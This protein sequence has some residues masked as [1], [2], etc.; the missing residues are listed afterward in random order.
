MAQ[1][2]HLLQAVGGGHPHPVVPAELVSGALNVHVGGL[3]LLGVHHVQVPQLLHRS[4]AAPDLVGVKDHDDPTVSPA[5]VVA[6]QVNE[7]GPCPVQILSGQGGQVLP[8]V[9]DVVSIH[10]QVVLPRPLFQPLPGPLLGLGGGLYR[11]EGPGLHRPIGAGE[12]LLQLLVQGQLGGVAPLELGGGLGLLGP[13]LLWQPAAVHMHVGTHLVPGHVHPRPVVTEHRARGVVHIP[14]WVVAPL[15]HHL[16]GVVARAVSVQAAG[17]PPPAL[18]IGGHLAPV[19]PHLGHGQGPGEHRHLPP[20]LGALKL[21]AHALHVGHGPAHTL[22]RHLQAEGIPGL[23]Q[24]GLPHHQTLADG[25]VGGLAEVASLG[26]LQVALAGEQ[27][28]LQIGDGGPGEHPHVLAL[29]QVCENEPLPVAVQHVLGAHGVNLQSRPPLQRLQ[30]QVH[31][32]VV[33]QRLKVAHTFHRLG[34]SLQVDDAA[35]AEGDIQHEAAA[36][37]PLQHLPVHLAH[38]L[39][40]HLLCMWLPLHLQ[41]GVLL[42]QAAQ[43]LQQGGGVHPL[44]GN[45]LI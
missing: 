17:E 18:G 26:V 20:H 24:D 27:G 36:Q 43:P 2:D 33:A 30:K 7:L 5:L 1:N 39:H 41:L 34:Q 13:L 32:G 25:P 14:V 8:G 37:L 29:H 15:L 11:V 22:P 3:R 9:D 23:Q 28:Q 21:P 38:E 12:D 35:G 16:L 6:Q 10:Q 19:V 42:L 45:H 4:F 40:P 44:R 31:L